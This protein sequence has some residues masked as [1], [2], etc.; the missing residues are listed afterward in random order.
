MFLPNLTKVRISAILDLRTGVAPARKLFEYREQPCRQY[1]G[2]RGT[3]AER[4]SIRSR[5]GLDL[6][7]AESSDRGETKRAKAFRAHNDTRLGQQQGHLSREDI[8]GQLWTSQPRKVAPSAHECLRTYTI[9]NQIAALWTIRKVGPGPGQCDHR[10]HDGVIGAVMPSVSWLALF[11]SS[12][13]SSLV[14]PSSGQTIW[15]L[16]SNLGQT[17]FHKSQTSSQRTKSQLGPECVTMR[18]K[19]QLG[20]RIGQVC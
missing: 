6:A 5:D 7:P 3:C 11:V 20:S 15:N 10:G 19:S 17:R 9:L 2:S 12:Q 14:L 18:D 16:A 13:P 8:Q 4:S 1:G